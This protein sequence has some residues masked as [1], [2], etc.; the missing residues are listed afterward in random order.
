M[1][2]TVSGVRFLRASLIFINILISYTQL[3]NKLTNSNQSNNSNQL[4]ET[5]T[6]YTSEKFPECPSTAETICNWQSH[7]LAR[8]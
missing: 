4:S 6:L 8:T 5:V 1:R 7:A 2:D 3:L